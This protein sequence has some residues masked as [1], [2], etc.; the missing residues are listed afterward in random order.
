MC[1]TCVHEV[2]GG[3]GDHRFTPP[4]FFSQNVPLLKSPAECREVSRTL[5]PVLFVLPIAHTCISRGTK[6]ST[7]IT[8]LSVHAD[9]LPALTQTYKSTLSMLS[10]LP[11]ESVYRQATEAILKQRAAVIEKANGD[12][13]AVERELDA[14][15]IEQVLQVAKDEQA[16]AAKMLEW[17]P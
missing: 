15:Q 10:Q 1:Y 7:G 16:L 6:V 11:A 14:G 2:P 3:T 4:C 9:P 8:G 17:K 5:N 12:V 13:E